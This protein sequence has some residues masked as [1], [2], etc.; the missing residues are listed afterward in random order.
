MELARVIPIAVLVLLALRLALQLWLDGLN[1]KHVLA[2]RGAVPEGFR[3]M[4]DEGTYAKSVQYTLAKGSLHRIELVYDFVILVAVLYSGFLPWVY[5]LVTHAGG[6][7]AFAGA[8]FLFGTSIVLSLPDL[9]LDWY[10]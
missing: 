2:H 6:N 7:S 5:G 3:G 10:H 8:L 1:R 9:P 4:L